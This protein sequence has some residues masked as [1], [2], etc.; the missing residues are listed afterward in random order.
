MATPCE[1]WARTRERGESATEPSISSP[2]FMG[3]GCMTMHDG[4]RRQARSPVNA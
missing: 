2:R 1:T 3:P 4:L